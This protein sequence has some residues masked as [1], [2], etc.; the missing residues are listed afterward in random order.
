MSTPTARVIPCPFRDAVRA[1]GCMA[2]LAMTLEGCMTLGDSVPPSPQ[3]AAQPPVALAAPPPQEEPAAKPEPKHLPK[4]KAR[5][6]AE[7]ASR[8][9]HP[10]ID[11]KTL[12]GLDQAGVRRILGSPS[13]V[14]SDHLSLTWIYRA[15][16]CSM[17][18]VFYP[19]LEDAS[20]HVL[21]FS[22]S[23]KDGN[24]IVPSDT[25]VSRILI[26]RSN[27]H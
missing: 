12:I 27:A 22:G 11:P 9:E 17:Q 14:K 19:S 10:T 23:N 6:R 16:S 25:C 3:P 1:I 24:P 15:P 4:K 8:V 5:A 26:A 18:L 13:G 2:I 20:F 7:P 21:K